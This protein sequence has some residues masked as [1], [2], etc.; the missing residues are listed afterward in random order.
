MIFPEW[1]Y[2]QTSGFDGIVESDNQTRID[3]VLSP[4]GFPA[5]SQA[6][7]GVDDWRQEYDLNLKTVYKD[8]FTLRGGT[9]I[10]IK[11]RLSVPNLP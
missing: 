9:L 6:P 8:F 2:R 11:D 7:G 4:F 1:R 10:K 3:N 5:A